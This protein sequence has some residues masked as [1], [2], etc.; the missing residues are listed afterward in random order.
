MA[1]SLPLPLPILGMIQT[2]GECV[3]AMLESV[4]GQKTNTRICSPSR[5]CA[6]FDTLSAAISF[7]G[8]KSRDGGREFIFNLRDVSTEVAAEVR[9]LIRQMRQ[10]YAPKW[11]LNRDVDDCDKAEVNVLLFL[12][13]AG[14]LAFINNNKEGEDVTPSSPPTP[15]KA[16]PHITRFDRKFS[17]SILRIDKRIV[18]TPNFSKK[19]KRGGGGDDENANKKNSVPFFL[20]AMIH[21]PVHPETF[22]GVRMLRKHVSS[23]SVLATSPKQVFIREWLMSSRNWTIQPLCEHNGAEDP[24]IPDICDRANLAWEQLDDIRRQECCKIW[25]NEASSRVT[26]PADIV[27]FIGHTPEWCSHTSLLV[28]LVAQ[29]S[30]RLLSGTTSVVN[31]LD[32]RGLQLLAKGEANGLVS[33]IKRGGHNTSSNKYQVWSDFCLK[34]ALH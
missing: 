28:K 9:L 19:R 8:V 34:L 33:D 10:M 27:E 2:D 17:R 22:D 32:V 16:N 14:R 24:D 12:E 29:I 18:R 13:F 25:L 26:H 3:R 21:A 20:A 30:R 15:L 5:Y 4:H 1:V 23:S 7:V 6:R 31:A 11:R